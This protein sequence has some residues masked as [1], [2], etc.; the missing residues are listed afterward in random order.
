MQS[1]GNTDS[2]DTGSPDDSVFS[3]EWLPVGWEY[4]YII[5]YGK[6][7]PKEPLILIIPGT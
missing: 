2:E 7:R 1:S 5:K 3:E 4:T 6:L